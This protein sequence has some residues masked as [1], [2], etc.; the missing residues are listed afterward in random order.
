MTIAVAGATG[1]TG[2]R[3][4]ARL[5]AKG[6]ALRCLVRPQSDI[7]VLP[8]GATT[9]PGDLDD[10]AAMERWLAGCDALVYCASMGFGHVPGVVAA[11]EKAGV[12]RAVFVSTTAIFTR[13]PAKSKAG[14]V[15][16]EESVRGS[17]LKWTILRPT[18]IYGAPGD[19]NMERLLRRVARPGPVFVPGDGRALIQP[20]HVDDLA[21][22]IVAALDCAA[23]ER[24]AYDVS[25][26]APLSL[27]AAIDAASAATGRT[28]WK[29]HLPLRPVALTL[30]A[31][32]SVTRGRCFPVK[33]EQVL[34][35]AEDKAFAHADAA[36][37][38]GFAP[39]AFEQGIAEEARLLGITGAH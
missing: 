23:A 29:L 21:D 11:A 24:K 25:G 34:R 15:A 12:V 8:Q 22:A 10:A 28:H 5:T 30:A 3:V 6:R 32:E 7:A 31:L 37:D 36:R 20:V 9:C 14:R 2:R 39:R 27:D 38:F 18:M 13:L 19:R 4:A 26:K 1:F 16:A 17:R 33:S 35:L